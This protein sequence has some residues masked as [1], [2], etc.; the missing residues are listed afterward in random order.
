VEIKRGTIVEVAGRKYQAEERGFQ[1]WW[2][3][4]CTEE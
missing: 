1:R 2:F 4:L 3:Q